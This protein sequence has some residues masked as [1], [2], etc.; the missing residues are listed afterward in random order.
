MGLRNR[1]KDR[2]IFS[3][4]SHPS[5]HVFKKSRSLFHSFHPFV[6]FLD[7]SKINDYLCP[8]SKLTMLSLPIIEMIK[9]K[10]GLINN[11]IIQI[12]Y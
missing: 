11:L 10:S 4:F 2:Q 5:L 7:I 1:I 12:G 6:F 9:K 8:K 3:F